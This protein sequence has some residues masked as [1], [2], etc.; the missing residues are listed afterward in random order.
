MIAISFLLVTGRMQP[1]L[2]IPFISAVVAALALPIMLYHYGRNL[3][4]KR[5]LAPHSA[6][7]CTICHYKLRDLPDAG[8][9]PECGTEYTRNDLVAKWEKHFGLVARYPRFTSK[10]YDPTPI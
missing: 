4:G 2:S 1:L 8:R 7:I 3:L 9:C 10:P 5:F 6:F